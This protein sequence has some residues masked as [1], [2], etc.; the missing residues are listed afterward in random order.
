MNRLD[1][2]TFLSDFGWS[3][4]YVAACE[5]T[6]ARLQP[7]ARVFHISHEVRSGD[8]AAGAMTL[9]RVAP[10]FPVAVHLAVIDPGV[11]TVGGLWP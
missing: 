3:G 1:I 7:H 8:V 10:L 4:G 2:I 9:E 5:A 11:G 6:V